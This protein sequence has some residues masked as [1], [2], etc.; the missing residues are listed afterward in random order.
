MTKSLYILPLDI[1]K[2]PI[3]KTE[4]ENLNILIEFC[5]FITS[6]ITKEAM[7]HQQ[8]HGYL[9]VADLEGIQGVRLNPNL[10]P[11]YFVFHGEFQEICV[12]LSKRTPLLFI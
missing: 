9:S 3:A 4:V 2:Y 8:K 5:N 6:D 1:N 10:E 7:V 12:K 11:N